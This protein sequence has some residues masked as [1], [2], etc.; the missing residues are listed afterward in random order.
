MAPACRSSGAEIARAAT[1]SSSPFLR[2]LAL[3]AFALASLAAPVPARAMHL[4]DG[5]LPLRWAAL[6]SGIAAVAV[7]VALVR[8]RQRTAEDRRVR[9]LVALVAALVFVLSC[10]PIPVP[11]V[12]TCSHPCGTGLAALI[13]GPWLTVLVAVAALALQALFLAHGGFT[14]LGADVVSMGIAGAFAGWAAF[15]ALRR[16]GAPLG[17]AAFA[18]GLLSDWATYAVT[19]LELAAALHGARPFGATALTIFAAFLPT[20]IPLGI[21]EGVLAAGAV[22][23]LLRRR[24]DL[25]ARSGL[26]PSEA[27]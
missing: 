18:A 6:W 9:P 26:A 12:G 5:I 2:A 17:A 27:A 13:V 7:A 3:P 15:H 10:M 24:P 21:L 23:F 4:A 16:V 20:Q 14:T 25:L 19:S 8:L 11:F 22:R 1:T